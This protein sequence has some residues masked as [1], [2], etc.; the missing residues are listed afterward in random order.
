[1]YVQKL[2]ATIQELQEQLN[3]HGEA[4]L[5][6]SNESDL[7]RIRRQNEEH[8]QL[9]RLQIKSHKADWEVERRYASNLH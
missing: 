9:L 3:Q 8:L 1:M 6:R 7:D 5:K 4:E 2:L